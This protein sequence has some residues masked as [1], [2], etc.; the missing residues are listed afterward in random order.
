M[1][2]LTVSKVGGKIPGRAGGTVEGEIRSRC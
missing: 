1:M 2:V